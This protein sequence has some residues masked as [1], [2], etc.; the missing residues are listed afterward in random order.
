[1]LLHALFLHLC[2][3]LKLR[4]SFCL[5]KRQAILHFFPL[6]NANPYVSIQVKKHQDLVFLLTFSNYVFSRKKN[7]NRQLFLCNFSSIIL[8]MQSKDEKVVQYL[9]KA[10]TARASVTIMEAHETHNAFFL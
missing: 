7:G 9:L 2:R 3:I 6:K 5:K 10:A 1:M 4:N 8:C